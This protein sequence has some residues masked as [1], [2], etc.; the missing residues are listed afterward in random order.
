LRYLA[1]VNLGVMI[2]GN[3]P[4]D[5][6]SVLHMR[7]GGAVTQEVQ[8]LA[9]CVLGGYT[10]A[11]RLVELFTQPPGFTMEIQERPVASPLA[12]LYPFPAAT[13]V[14]ATNMVPMAIVPH[15]L[16]RGEGASPNEPQS[17]QRGLAAIEQ[18][19]S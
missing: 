9:Q 13:I 2:P 1:E 16:A 7:F 3:M 18:G 8:M 17:S 19:F 15:A 5:V 11:G 14:W 4:P 12:R 10:S 6:Q